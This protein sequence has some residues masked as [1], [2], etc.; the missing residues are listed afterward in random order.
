[1][2]GVVEVFTVCPFYIR[3]DPMTIFPQHLM[4]THDDT[5]TCKFLLQLDMSQ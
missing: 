5:V 3:N 4:G 1:M 2:W